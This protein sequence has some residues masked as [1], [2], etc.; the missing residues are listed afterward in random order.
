MRLVFYEYLILCETELGNLCASLTLFARQTSELS[1]PFFNWQSQN[2]VQGNCA[3]QSYAGLVPF[4][5]QI[6]TQIFLNW[7]LPGL[8]R[9]IFRFKV[10]KHII[11]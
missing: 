11:A 8:E 5:N 9:Y 1:Y 6:W 3:S 7:E 4:G 2:W 10:R